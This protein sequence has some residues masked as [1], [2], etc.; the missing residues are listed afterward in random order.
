MNH[1]FIVKSLEQVLSLTK[2]FMPVKSETIF[3]KD[4]FLR[5]LAKDIIVETNMPLFQRSCMDGYALA[6]S[7]TFGASSSSPALLE[8]V[9]TIQ[10]G[11]KPDFC[12]KQNQAAEIST[13]G[14]LPKGADSV[15]MVEHT[16]K[17]DDTM[18]EIH[19]SV[20]FLQNTIDIAEDFAKNDIAIPKRTFIRAQEQ[21]LIAGLGYKSIQ[22]FKIPKVG[23]ISSGDE[24]VPIEIKPKLGE[25]RDINSY[26]ISA[27]IQ[28]AC[29]VP[30]CYGIVKD[31]K[32]QLKKVLE[33][34]CKET[35]MVLISGGSS[36]GTKDFTIDVLSSMPD[37]NILV[38][39]ISISPGKP[40][41]LAKVGNKSV[42]GLPGQ[43]TS[44]MV[45]LKIVVIP[46]LDQIKGLAKKSKPIKISAKLSR[47]IASA[48]GRKDF[49][50]VM[51]K[52]KDNQLI[53]EPVLGKSG[54]IRPMIYADGLL[55]IDA[56]LEGME[57][58][59]IVD[60]ILI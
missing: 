23:I 47:N 13:G 56:N 39:G 21:G 16:E 37:S 14:M 30:V 33:K 24:I 32:I 20:A 27:L 22:A 4:S 50:R 9:G 60:I 19:K 28:E 51:L 59:S 40:T 29:A 57:K 58:G 49:T 44:A 3:T 48:Q 8:I 7:S 34:A 17:I 54:L 15:V 41:I 5:V 36:V 46:F 6:A 45:V 42:W 26:T 52:T 35:D 12:L 18:V 10:M 38:H 43:V 31:D 11:D 53:A 25:I 55:E 2:E 1:F